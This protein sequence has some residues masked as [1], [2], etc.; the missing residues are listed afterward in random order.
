[1]GIPTQH[2]LP[3]LFLVPFVGLWEWKSSYRSSEKDL[4]NSW[5]LQLSKN[6]HP[7]IS[8]GDWNLFWVAADDDLRLFTKLWVAK[9]EI[10]GKYLY[11]QVGK[12][13]L[14]VMYN[15]PKLKIAPLSVYWSARCVD[16]WEISEDTFLQR[17]E[18]EYDR[19]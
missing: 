12:S 19:V 8:N 1:M 2:G 7:E 4:P 5:R 16:E 6:V 14:I 15:P 13:Q 3:E 11:G 18:E 17:R 9:S 10:A